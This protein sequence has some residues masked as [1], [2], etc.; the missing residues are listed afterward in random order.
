MVL[1]AADFL[2]EKR[3]SPFS[4]LTA[5]LSAVFFGFLISEDRFTSS[6]ILGIIVGVIV[7]KKVD[8]PN[9]I[10][11]LVLTIIFALVFEPE[12]PVPFLTIMVSLF[13]FIDE[14]GHEIYSQKRGLLSLFFHYRL[15]LKLVMICMAIVSLIQVIHLVGFLCFDLAYEVTNYFLVYKLG[16]H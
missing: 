3:S 13:T 12:S 4:Y 9:M 16:E 14:T 2:G 10:F 5:L 1:K 15:A 11:G 8:R 6:I 7:S